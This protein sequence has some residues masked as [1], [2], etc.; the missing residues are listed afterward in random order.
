MPRSG[1]AQHDSDTEVDNPIPG[2]E[3]RMAVKFGMDS[4][5]HSRVLHS[6]Q[7]F[8]MGKT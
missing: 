7:G 1:E 2:N 3:A 8:R 4:S 6:G 5:Q